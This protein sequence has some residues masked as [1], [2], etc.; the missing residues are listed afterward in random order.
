MLQDDAYSFADTGT[1]EQSDLSSLRVW[2]EEIHDLDSSHQ[3]FLGFA[4]RR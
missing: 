1:A 2:C 4:L 3:D